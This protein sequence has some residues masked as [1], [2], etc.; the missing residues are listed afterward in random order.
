MTSSYEYSYSIV[1]GRLDIIGEALL[2]EIKSS[3]IIVACTFSPVESGPLC[4]A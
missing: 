1:L 4:P 2:T 3:D